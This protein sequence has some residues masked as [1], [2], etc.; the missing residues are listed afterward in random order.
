MIKM[1]QNPVHTFWFL[2][3]H[4]FSASAMTM[5]SLIHNL[6]SSYLFSETI[7][8][9]LPGSVESFKME[10]LVG[11]T[12]FEEDIL[13]SEPVKNSL[14][15]LFVG[16]K[17]TRG[18]MILVNSLLSADMHTRHMSFQWNWHWQCYKWNSV[19]FTACDN[20]CMIT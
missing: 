11:F 15:L 17:I 9:V 4:K 2:R 12:I 14:K 19:N 20:N 18:Q 13:S 7:S 5:H 16:A 1:N 6:L 8:V 10:C 3:I